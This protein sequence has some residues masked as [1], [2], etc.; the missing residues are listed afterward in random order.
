MS[1]DTPARLRRFAGEFAV[2]VLGVLVALFA[3]SAWESRQEGQLAEEYLERLREEVRLNREELALDVAFN[4]VNCAGA[5]AAWAGLTGRGEGSPEELLR[6][7]W[8]T[9]LN[10]NA[11]YRTTTYD[12]LVASGRLRIIRDADLRERIIR[13]YESDDLDIWRPD[14]N[15]EYRRNVLR[16]LPPAWTGA[17]LETCV[18]FQGLSEDWASCWVPLEEGPE[19]W[20][21]RIAAIPGIREQLAD[22]TYDVCRFDRYLVQSDSI[23]GELETALGASH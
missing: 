22:R 15:A 12:D 19:R 1:E 17:M 16:T 18:T 11:D 2:I 7:L 9:A 8:L 14:L 3:Q 20:V 10:R 4:D 23:L 13:Y 6:S 5:E 21:G